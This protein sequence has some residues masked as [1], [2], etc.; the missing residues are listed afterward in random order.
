MAEKG[1]EFPLRAK[2]ALLLGRGLLHLL[3]RTWRF[4]VVNGAP[5]G[6]LRGKEGFIF[7]TWHGHLLPSS[8]ITGIGES[9]C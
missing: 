2:A 7:S 9:P 3:G 8:G 4:R 6:Q 1:E 5:L